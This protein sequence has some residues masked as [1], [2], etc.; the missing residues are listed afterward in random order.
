[1]LNFWAKRKSCALNEAKGRQKSRTCKHR[2]VKGRYYSSILFI[3]S[4]VSM[5]WLG[6]FPRIIAAE[7]SS[8]SFNRMTFAEHPFDLSCSLK[9]YWAVINSLLPLIDTFCVTKAQT[10][11]FCSIFKKTIAFLSLFI[12]TVLIWKIRIYDY[13]SKLTLWECN[14]ECFSNDILFLLFFPKIAGQKTDGLIRV[15]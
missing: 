7:L 12:E 5:D 14:E 4:I 1:M 9:S 10:Y 15:I 11:S 8:L 6:L 3:E 2:T 13:Y